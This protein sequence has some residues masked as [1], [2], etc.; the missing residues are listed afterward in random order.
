VI[1]W[2]EAPARSPARASPARTAALSS[3][4]SKIGISPPHEALLLGAAAVRAA[5]ALVCLVEWIEARVVESP[6]AMPIDEALRA[7]LPIETDLFALVLADPA[8]DH[9]TG[10]SVP[11]VRVRSDGYTIATLQ[12]IV[13]EV[14]GGVR[15]VRDIKEQEVVL[16]RAE[17]RDDPR[18]DAYV[19]GWREAVLVVL[20]QQEAL[21]KRDRAAFERFKHSVDCLMPHDLCAPEVLGLKRP[22]DAAAFTDALLSKKRFGQF[23]P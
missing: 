6:T 21:L 17:H 7:A 4:A 11:G 15:Q 3:I 9:Y 1:V 23:L 2:R 13:C 5:M 22:Q 18:V 19:A 10:A 20:T 16:L 8:S 14:A 12:L